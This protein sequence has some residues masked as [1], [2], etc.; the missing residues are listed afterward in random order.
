MVGSRGDERVLYSGDTE[1]LDE[2]GYLF[3][4][5]RTSTFIKCS[6]FRIS[7]TEVEDVVFSSGLVVDVVA[8][9]RPDELLG[10]VV[11]VAVTGI[12]SD[13]ID[14]GAIRRHRKKPLPPYAIPREI[15]VWDGPTMPRTANGKVDRTAV[16]KHF[17]GPG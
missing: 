13:E 14:T 12:D 8:F 11:H 5:A 2:E 3:F 4:A 9:G 15:H 1:H 17:S 6:D 10:Q 16:I 7:P